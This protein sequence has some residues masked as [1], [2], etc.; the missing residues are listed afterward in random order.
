MDI[1]ITN[2]RILPSM[3]RPAHKNDGAIDLYACI[4]EPVKLLCGQSVKFSAG[5]KVA[6]PNG[7]LGLILPRSGSGS[8]GA[9]LK[10]VTGLID[11]GYRGE[12]IINLTNNSNDDSRMMVIDPMER[13]MQLAIISHYDYSQL[14]FV[15][16]LD[17]TERGEG[18]FGS[19]GS[20]AHE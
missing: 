9:H 18:G 11:S 14:N 20:T 3:I 4:D 5:I 12:I 15:D 8:L 16:S 17:S 13:V 2:D 7:Y 10:N 19:S 1:Q 6:I